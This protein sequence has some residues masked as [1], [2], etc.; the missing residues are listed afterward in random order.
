M[1][2]QQ[3]TD[4]A[5]FFIPAAAPRILQRP[6]LGK[7]RK[8]RTPG[9]PSGS[10]STC[11]TMSRNS[12]CVGRSRPRSRRGFSPK[13][14]SARAQVASNRRCWPK[15]MALRAASSQA[16]PDAARDHRQ[17][18][19]DALCKSTTQN[20]LM[21]RP[22]VSGLAALRKRLATLQAQPA[23]RPFCFQGVCV[24]K[25]SPKTHRCPLS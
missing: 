23:S 2:N 5:E 13:K 14:T 10:I 20:S 4:T 3:H 12:K 19:V 7:R 1:H 11:D 16:L 24:E 17:L 25:E 22:V 8:P 18:L 9:S 15:G 6:G 21:V